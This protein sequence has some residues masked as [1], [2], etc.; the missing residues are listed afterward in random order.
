MIINSYY[1]DICLQKR[2]KSGKTFDIYSLKKKDK[3]IV[4]NENVFNNFK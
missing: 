4:K 3:V 1:P 2:S